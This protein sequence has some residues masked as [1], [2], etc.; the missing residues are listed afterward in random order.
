MRR[1][2]KHSLFD[3]ILYIAA[4]FIVFPVILLFIWAFVSRWPWPDM[5]PK[6]FSLKGIHALFEKHSTAIPILFSSILF[7]LLCTTIATIIGFLSARA[8]ALYS[9]KGKTFFRFASMLPMIISS[10]VFSMGI[11]SIFIRWGLN[12]RAIGVLICHVIYALPYTVN[13]LLG[14]THQMGTRFE[15]QAA[16]LGC[17][18]RKTFIQITFP[19]AMPG[20]L[21]TLSMGYILSFSQYFITLLIGGGRVITFSMLMVPF[22]S[23]GDRTVA[24]AYVGLFLLSSLFVF[25]LF[26]R[27]GMKMRKKWEGSI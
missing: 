16:V 22:I 23:G 9:F 20:I 27:L 15:E 5:L 12:D 25:A 6:Y 14:T 10:N 1:T 7:S 26:D 24:S 11:H 2:N 18:K 19:L 3:I 13:I 17:G 8:L 4:L 21:A